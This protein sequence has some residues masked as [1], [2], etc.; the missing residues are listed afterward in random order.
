MAMRY[1]LLSLCWFIALIPLAVAVTWFGFGHLLVQL[2][3]YL[4]AV[5]VTKRMIGKFTS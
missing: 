3:L 4:A 1:R 5:V 2:A